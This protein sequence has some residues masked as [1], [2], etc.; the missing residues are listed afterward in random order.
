MGPLKNVTI[1][2]F[3]QKLDVF[4]SCYR[5]N[6]NCKCHALDRLLHPPR[7]ERTAVLA[8]L[9]HQRGW[10]SARWPV[11]TGPIT[12][13]KGPLWSCTDTPW[14]T[15]GAWCSLYLT[16]SAAGPVSPFRWRAPLTRTAFTSLEMSLEQVRAAGEVDLW[17][18][19]FPPSFL[20]LEVCISVWTYLPP[21]PCID[22]TFP[23]GSTVPVRGAVVLCYDLFSV[24]RAGTAL[25]NSSLR[26]VLVFSE[27]K[28]LL[29]SLSTSMERHIIPAVR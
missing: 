12:A 18:F 28:H 26:D 17:P 29:S 11:A 13:N 27:N 23:E 6:Q 16:R 7:W 25:T 20:L 3:Q 2:V 9:Q 19:H 8:L 22:Q 24:C 14:Q 15:C 21:F 10:S 1:V 4:C 5:S